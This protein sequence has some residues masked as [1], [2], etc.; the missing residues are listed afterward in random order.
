MGKPG[1]KLVGLL[2]QDKSNIILLHNTNTLSR[3]KA[4]LK[5][6]FRYESQLTYST[7]R[8]NPSDPVEINYF[9]VERKEYGDYTIIIEISKKVIN[10]YTDLA[11]ATGKTIEEILSIDEPVM[12]DN[13]EY[14][15]TISHYYIKGIF[16]NKTGEVLLNSVFDPDFE[17][18]LY[19]DNINKDK[20]L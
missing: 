7:D 14:I 17:S 8:I 1:N 18:T 6:G 4:I 10:K 5:H 19:L 2:S 13:D 11:E 16:N 9:L 20:A 12:S 3:A 15:F